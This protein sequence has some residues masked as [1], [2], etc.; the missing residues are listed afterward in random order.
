[1]TTGRINQVTILKLYSPLNKKKLF[2]HKPP[3]KEAEI[4]TRRRPFFFSSIN[5]RGKS[6]ANNNFAA[7]CIVILTIQLPPL[8]F[9]SGDSPLQDRFSH[10][11]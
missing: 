7:H 9:F 8:K 11:R 1:M 4:G 2:N 10:L 6:L 5:K 3:V